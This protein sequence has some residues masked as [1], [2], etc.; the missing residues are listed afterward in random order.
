MPLRSRVGNALTRVA[1]HLLS[2]TK[3]ADTQTGLRA[4]G[5]SQLTYLLETE[6]SGYDYEMNVLLHCKRHGIPLVEVPIQTVYLDEHNSASHFHSLR[7]S[8]KVLKMLLKFASVS[9]ISFALDYGLFLLLST[10][11]QQFAYG[12]LCSNVAARLGSGFF[13]YQLNRTLVFHSQE[14]QRKTLVEYLCWRPILLANNGILSLF[15]YGLSLP[16]WLAKLLTE[17]SLFLGQ[18]HGTDQGDLSGRR[19][20]APKERGG[21]VPCIRSVSPKRPKGPWRAVVAVLLDVVI[22]AGIALSVYYFNYQ[23]PQRCALPS[24]AEQGTL[25]AGGPLQPEGSSAGSLPLE[26]KFADRFSDTVTTTDTS[27]REQGPLHYGDRPH[28][29]EGEQPGGL[30]CG[31]RLYHKHPLLPHLFFPGHLWFR[32]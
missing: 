9:L 28:L 27:Y 10:A 13:N 30:L 1:F 32:V 20:A 31:G 14:N 11:T 22:T 25:Y 19:R 17:G 21:E 16:L 5:F 24:M 18:P 8:W 15:A 12:L 2:R 6:G 4:F 7:D 23:V 26:G 3:V 29:G